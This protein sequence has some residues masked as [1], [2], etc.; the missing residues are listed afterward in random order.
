MYR[1]YL[2]TLNALDELAI[3]KKIIHEFELLN[4]LGVQLDSQVVQK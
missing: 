4:I 1:T 3:K 2:Q